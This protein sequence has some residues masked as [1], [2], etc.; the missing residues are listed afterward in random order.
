MLDGSAG[1]PLKRAAATPAALARPLVVA[2]SLAVL[3]A[4]V[5]LA[6]LGRDTGPGPELLPQKAGRDQWTPSWPKPA[7]TCWVGGVNRPG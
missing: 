5:A 7:G 4:G 2:T 6:L 1:M 3:V